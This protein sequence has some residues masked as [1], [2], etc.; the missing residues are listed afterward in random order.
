MKRWLRSGFAF[1]MALWLS[2]CMYPQERIEQANQLDQHIARV[3]GAVDQYLKQHKVLPYKYTEEDYKLTT[4]YL[5][6]FNVLQ[7]Y[8]DIPP[9]A[10]EKGGHFLYVLV[11]V[12]KQPTV[13]VF[14]LRV[15]ETVEKVQLEVDAY[16]REQGSLP[17]GEMVAPHYHAIDFAKLR[18]DPVKVQSPYSVGEELPLIMDDTGLVYVDYRSDAMQMLQSS[19]EK[20]ADGSDLR[21]WMAKQSLFVPAFSPP[22]QL[23]KGDPVFTGR[24]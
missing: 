16:R 23:Q 3:Q 21:L 8:V 5:V 9:T 22:M 11:D 10:F 15:N 17:A 14:D 19:K 24:P 7:G 6:D 1:L 12:E 20:P 13:R 4:K 18:M 2:G